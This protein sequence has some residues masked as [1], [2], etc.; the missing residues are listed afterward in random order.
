M[1]P[2]ARP[3]PMRAL[4]RRWRRSPCGAALGRSPSSE[5]PGRGWTGTA[6]SLGLAGAGAWQTWSPSLV[7]DAAGA[8]ASRW[9]RKL[10]VQLSP[11]AAS[12]SAASSSFVLGVGLFGSVYLMPV[13]LAFVRG[14]DVPRSART[15][16]WYRRRA[17]P[18]R[19]RGREGRSSSASRRAA[20]EAAAASRPGFAVRRL[21]L[22]VR[23][24]DAWR[25]TG[26]DG[27]VLAA[28]PRR[29]L[30]PSVLPVAADAAGARASSTRSGAVP[31]ASGLFNLDAQLGGAIGLALIDTVIWRAAAP[32]HARRRSSTAWPPATRS[33]PPSSACRSIS[34]PC[35]R[36]DR[37][38]NGDPGHARKPLV[39]KA[40]MTMAV[41]DAWAM[42]ALT[43]VA[44]ACVP[45]AGRAAAP[46]LSGPCRPCRGACFRPRPH[47]PEPDAPVDLREGDLGENPVRLHWRRL[48][49]EDGADLLGKA[50][51]PR[52]S[53]HAG[54][55]SCRSGSS[56]TAADPRSLRTPSARDAW[57]SAASPSPQA[58][59]G[60]PVRSPRNWSSP[61]MRARESRPRR[62]PRSRRGASC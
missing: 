31:D 29:G 42:I 45:F 3:P 62:G 25:P 54:S 60:R 36:P 2:A 27:A 6:S 16:C 23:R 41:N 56:V 48:A 28:G 39:E 55:R 44:L 9:S 40:A 53:A 10:Q 61:T 19:A 7:A 50:P 32:V 24:P 34:S 33:P 59:P 35:A 13:F 57:R 30:R 51:G 22:S 26:C 20:A 8:G 11:T 58:P 21:G 43:L 38:T 14:H 5:A 49:A 1:R 46:R 47:A 17:V 15:P 12:P 18:D 4:A 52:A 37:S